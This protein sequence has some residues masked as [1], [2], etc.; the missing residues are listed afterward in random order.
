MQRKDEL[1]RLLTELDDHADDEGPAANVWSD[2]V[3]AMERA[4][5]QLHDYDAGA[6]GAEALR[7]A[8]D[9]LQA[10]ITLLAAVHERLELL[11]Q[12]PGS[13]P[14]G[15]QGPQ[16]VPLRWAARGDPAR[17]TSRTRYR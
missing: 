4:W 2:V 9:E 5:E 11:A 10:G 13:I 15:C 8:A 14:G 16:P 12:A 6:R 3:T 7:R 1:Q 17:V